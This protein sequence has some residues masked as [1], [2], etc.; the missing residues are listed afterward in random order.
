MTF[1]HRDIWS[2]SPF[3]VSLRLGHGIL[4]CIIQSNGSHL[5]PTK[6][7]AR[8]RYW[9]VHYQVSSRQ[10]LPSMTC[11]AVR[12]WVQFAHS[13]QINEELEISL[14]VSRW[15]LPDCANSPEQPLRG[16]KL[17]EPLSRNRRDCHATGRRVRRRH[18]K[19][20][21][22]DSNCISP[23]S[24]ARLSVRGAK[25]NAVGRRPAGQ[26]VKRLQPASM[27][28]SYSDWP[29]TLR[30]IEETGA[31]LS[32][33]V[34]SRSRHWQPT[35]FYCRAA[36]RPTL[37][38]T[39]TLPFRVPTV[40]WPLNRGRQL[41]RFVPTVSHSANQTNRRFCLLVFNLSSCDWLVSIDNERK[42]SEEEFDCMTTFCD[43][44]VAAYAITGSNALSVNHKTQEKLT[45]CWT[46]AAD[47]LANFLAGKS[48]E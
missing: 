11:R 3:W 32:R 2:I 1:A 26:S 22:N 43:G 38:H 18:R 47:V 4:D 21:R 30:P 33:R 48:T 40:E 28:Y 19:H 27:F 35:I 34:W 20:C 29:P 41:N 6:R 31:T 36:D 14:V 8:I 23:S 15:L 42:S 45:N 39:H 44:P 10:N 12:N 16:A 24:S 9:P 46:E 25:F 7:V 5:M 13:L 17:I 37:T